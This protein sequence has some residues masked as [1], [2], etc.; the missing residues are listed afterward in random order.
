MLK[1]CMSLNMKL[2]LMHA[3]NVNRDFYERFGER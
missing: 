1:G 2:D 3:M